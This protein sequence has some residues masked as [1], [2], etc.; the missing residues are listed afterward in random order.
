[1]LNSIRKF[2]N[3]LWAKILLCIV[4]VPFVFW[5]MGNVFSGGNKNIIAKINNKKIS[6]QDFMNH[7]NKLNINEDFIRQKLN[8]GILDEILNDL[9]SQ[10]LLEFEINDLNIQISDSSLSKIIKS[11]EDF[12]D[13]SNMFSRIKYEKY[14]I[15]NNMSSTMY[16]K[17]LN[18]NSKVQIHR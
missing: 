3:T 12:K 10:K 17:K 6:T 9:I 15:T 18:T 16:E 5:G 7:I 11:N 14:L 13:E 2:S 1:M 8:Q 4:I